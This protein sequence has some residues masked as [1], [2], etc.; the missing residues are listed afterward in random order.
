MSGRPNVLVLLS[1]YSWPA[2]NVVAATLAWMTARAG[3]LSE[4]YYDSYRLGSHFGGGGLEK[5]DNGGAFG[6]LFWSGR[7]LERL[8]LLNS[9]AEVHYVI[10]GSVALAE[11][12]PRDPGR[13]VVSETDP[14]MIYRAVM[15]KLGINP[16]RSAVWIGTGRGKLNEIDAY[17]YPEIHDRQALG[18]GG[19]FDLRAAESLKLLEIEK[20]TGLFC[21]KEER[22]A[23][24]QAG[25]D[26]ETRDELNP[27]D[28]Y[29]SVT[30]RMSLRLWNPGDGFFAGDPVVVS[31]WLPWNCRHGRLPIYGEPQSESLEAMAEQIQAGPSLVF[32]RQYDDRDFQVLTGLGRCF[33]LVDPL[34]PPFPV[35]S[36]L[37]NG[38]LKET[39]PVSL[40]EPSDADL[41]G[42]AREG[43]VLA[44][45]L[46]WSGAVR[47]L[48][49]MDRLFELAASMELRMGVI[50]TSESYRFGWPSPLKSVDWPVDR[51]GVFPYVEF[52]LGSFGE[53][54][55]LEGYA[56]TERVRESLTRAMDRIRQVTGG[57][58][59]PSGW[60][61][62]LDGKLVPS[63]NGVGKVRERPFGEFISDRPEKKLWEA[64]RAVG[65]RYAFST[66]GF[67]RPAVL[68]REKDFIVLTQT[69]GGWEGW[70]PFVDIASL[71][72]LLE[73]EKKVIATG[74]PG[75]L[76]G[77]LDSCL[78]TFSNPHWSRGS[79][80]R[81]MAQLLVDGGRSGR[82]V[83]VTPRT[84]ARY[85]RVLLDG[86]YIKKGGPVGPQG[87]TPW[88]YCRWVDSRVRKKIREKGWMQG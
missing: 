37:H 4:V 88:G 11:L 55:G 56:D 83:N 74:G 81:R 68:Y 20:V 26:W 70:S 69:A 79:E 34:R 38:T 46:F 52:L 18:F 24:Q 48:E 75:W 36:D 65:I 71:D 35:I 50:L 14:A 78:W 54:I 62:T 40:P 85:A 39:S 87:M 51:G 67:G 28:T 63:G 22:E 86:G 84:L 80:L 57:D 8:L 7:H 44:S 58:H 30:Q 5:A 76:V 3:W 6:S 61:P 17:C 33:Q 32:G 16:P 31:Y 15:G 47:E 10:V 29:G 60:W 41:E 66:Y 42:F 25:F 1:D 9:M 49:N 82:L 21:T 53:G 23:A 64:V 43:K 12:I 2:K 59:V 77:T 27:D 73:A 13:T 19:T 72:D 45:L